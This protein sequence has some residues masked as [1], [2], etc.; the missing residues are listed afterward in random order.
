M[1]KKEDLEK[2]TLFDPMVDVESKIAAVPGNYAILL[3]KGSK[4]PEIKVPYTS[5]TILYDGEEY[6]VIYVGIS[7]KNLRKRDYKNHFN[8]DN[9]GKST[10]RKSIG[11]LM[12]LKKTY[13]TEGEEGK[14]KP[15]IKFIDTD[16]IVLSEWMHDNLLLLF[17]ADRNFKMIE[18]EM[19]EVLNPPLNISNNHNS[20]NKDYRALLKTLR[21]D[22]SD[23]E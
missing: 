17:K 15:K 12:G 5:S 2:F 7:S 18:D 11:S 3:R 14:D 21:N 4:L 23:L 22:L 13:R 19:I 1:F 16:E 6:E 20:V 10:L 9:A 8:D